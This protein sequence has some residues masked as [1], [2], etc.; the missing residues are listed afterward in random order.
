MDNRSRFLSSWNSFH[1]LTFCMK[2]KHI[3]LMISTLHVLRFLIAQYC[4][5]T[6][7]RILIYWKQQ[8]NVRWTNK[9]RLQ[10]SDLYQK[11]V[12][13]ERYEYYLALLPVTISF[14]KYG[15]LSSY[16][17]FYTA[18]S[19]WSKKFFFLF[20]KFSTLCQNS[21]FT[22]LTP[23]DFFGVSLKK[24]VLKQFCFFANFFEKKEHS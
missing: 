7:W 9:H 12:R 6:K 24:K 4:S 22:F 11:N 2:N 5:G 23:S 1:E 3:Y 8:S 17:M 13:T 15:S 21:E 18:S 10:M 14:E 19:G 16:H 20:K